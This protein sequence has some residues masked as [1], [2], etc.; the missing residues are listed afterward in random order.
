MRP[1]L[2]YPQRFGQP[3]GRGENTLAEDFAKWAAW[4]KDRVEPKFAKVFPADQQGRR[5]AVYFWAR[6]MRC[7]NPSCRADIP[8]LKDRWLDNNSRRMSWVKITA[9]PGDIRLEV[10]NGEP[11]PDQDPSQGTVRASSVTCPGC[12]TAAAATDVRAYGSRVGFGR[13]LYAVLD[14][15]KENRTYRE[16]RSDEIEGA[17]SLATE[18]IENL[19]EAPNDIGCGSSEVMQCEAF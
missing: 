18:L 8:L 7:P 19:A 1:R 3:D 2:D 4:A 15:S 10:R 14:V 5:P 13:H 6:T 12:G 11:T 16:P 9:R 17:E